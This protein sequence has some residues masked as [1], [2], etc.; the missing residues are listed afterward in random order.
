[1]G[2]VLRGSSYTPRAGEGEAEQ[3][4]IRRFPVSP[5]R[6]SGKRSEMKM[7]EA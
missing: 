3:Q 2:G 5:A 4:F 6:P 1:M 7:N